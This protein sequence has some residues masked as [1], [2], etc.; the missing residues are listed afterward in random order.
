MRNS[1][2]WEVWSG[3]CASNCS[4]KH[5]CCEPRSRREAD[6]AGDQLLED[7][8]IGEVA[9]ERLDLRAGERGVRARRDGA[10]RD[11]ALERAVG[12]GEPPG[13]G[14]ERGRRR[15]DVG[16]PD[17]ALVDGDL[18]TIVALGLREVA[19]VDGFLV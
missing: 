17:Q 12:V 16:A 8:A 10:Q 3:L 6:D 19:E 5:R 1:C 13:R 18:D 2:S 7:D 4:A 9:A 15:D 11:V 14:G